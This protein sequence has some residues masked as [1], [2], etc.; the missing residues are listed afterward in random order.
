MGLVPPSFGNNYVLVAVDYMSKWVE[1]VAFPTNDA[2]VIVDFL[3]NYIFSS[4]GVPRALI[5][6]EGAHFL[7]KLM[8]NLLRKYNAKHKVSTSY[9]P[10]TSGRL[11]SLI[12]K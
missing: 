1:V 5:S 7:K 10:Q 11:K 6:D 4:F 9:H 12:D 2:K 8:E 3:K